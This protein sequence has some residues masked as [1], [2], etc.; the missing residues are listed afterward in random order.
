MVMGKS[1]WVSDFWS[2]N[3]IL[4][5]LFIFLISSGATQHLAQRKAKHAPLIRRGEESD[6]VIGHTCDP[7]TLGTEVEVEG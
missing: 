7:N 1:A 6:M 2:F 4:F 5:K 3:F